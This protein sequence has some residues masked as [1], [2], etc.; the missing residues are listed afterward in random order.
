MGWFCL[1]II[2][3]EFK[4][5]FNE[6]VA[7]EVRV[8]GI[9]LVS[10]SVERVAVSIELDGKMNGIDIMFR[11]PISIDRECRVLLEEGVT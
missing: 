7:V 4:G 2:G 9:C 11:N 6:F 1:V 8:D 10:G 3:N 5:M